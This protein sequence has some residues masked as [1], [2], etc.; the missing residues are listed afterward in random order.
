ML[1]RWLTLQGQGGQRAPTDRHSQRSPATSC[2]CQWTCGR[3]VFRSV[4]NTNACFPPE[5]SERRK[6]GVSASQPAS[7]SSA[8]VDREGE[9][10]GRIRRTRR[11]RDSTPLKMSQ[12]TSSAVRRR[13]R[14]SLQWGQCYWSGV[15]TIC[16][17]QHERLKG[18]THALTPSCAH[19]LC[20][21]SVCAHARLSYPTALGLG[22]KQQAVLPYKK[23]FE[24]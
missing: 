15:V 20:E 9:R 3:A 18:F 8:C 22:C 17:S 24:L 10:V 21:L 16:S 12:T 2:D 13:R 23:K 5:E 6:W 4:N 1:H 7:H 14:V 11:P 19:A